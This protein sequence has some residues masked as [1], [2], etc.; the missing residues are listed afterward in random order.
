MI[1]FTEKDIWKYAKVHNIRF[2]DIY[3]P[4]FNM[5]RNGCYCC[6]FGCHIANENNFQI[7]Q[8]CYPRLFE[9]IMDKW[10]FKEICKQCNVN[11]YHINPK[12]KTVGDFEKNVSLQ[13]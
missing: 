12:Q 6:G 5:N 9:N 4:P 11:M 10:G 2:A 8:R 3:Y 7:L 1:F 13:K